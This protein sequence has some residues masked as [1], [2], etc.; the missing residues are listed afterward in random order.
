M[1][2]K[3]KK[4]KK[5]VNANNNVVIVPFDK[6]RDRDVIFDGGVTFILRH[7]TTNELQHI[8]FD[9]SRS[10]ANGATRNEIADRLVTAVLSQVPKPR[11]LQIMEDNGSG[12]NFQVITHDQKALR[13]W[14]RSLF[15][16]VK[17]IEERKT[18]KIKKKKNNSNNTDQAGTTDH[19]NNNNNSNNNT[20]ITDSQSVSEM[21]SKLTSTQP[22]IVLQNTDRGITT[23]IGALSIN[24]TTT[25]LTDSTMTKIPSIVVTSSKEAAA[26]AISVSTKLP[27]SPAL[28]ASTALMVTPWS[29]TTTTT[30]TAI[31]PTLPSLAALSTSVT[32]E[33]PATKGNQ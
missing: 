16:V 27:L 11:F 15:T 6:C 3:K 8:Y 32:K 19:N 14:M 25:T 26:V 13:K 30:T 29:A 22:K 2:K 33:L 20:A 17:N 31:T 10:R 4:K 9:D 24:C 12:I 23:N 21:T 28:T 7:M 18:N 1:K 5:N